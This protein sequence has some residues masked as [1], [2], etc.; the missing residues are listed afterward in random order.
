MI[1]QDAFVLIIPGCPF[2]LPG[3]SSNFNEPCGI[4]VTGL[5]QLT[6]IKPRNA[7]LLL[8]RCILSFA[9]YHDKTKSCGV[10]INDS[11]GK[12]V[13]VIVEK[14][15]TKLNLD[16]DAA[17]QIADAFLKEKKPEHNKPLERIIICFSLDES[18]SQIEKTKWNFV[19]GSLHEEHQVDG[20]LCIVE[21]D[22][23]NC[24]PGF[25]PETE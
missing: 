21:I 1:L 22:D 3:S 13:P 12:Q 4:I 7:S 10:V 15:M 8:T 2:I 17:L 6:E 19:F 25:L 5:E 24:L 11:G 18:R 23:E 16:R 14:I 20:W 9:W